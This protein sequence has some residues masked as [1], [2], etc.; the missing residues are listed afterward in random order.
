LYKAFSR[1]SSRPHG[2]LAMI[3]APD[4]L[5]TRSPPNA[6]SVDWIDAC[7]WIWPNFMTR[8]AP[9]GANRSRDKSLAFSDPP[10]GTHPR[11]ADWGFCYTLLSSIWTADGDRAPFQ[12][13]CGGSIACAH[14]NRPSPISR[15][16]SAPYRSSDPHQA[17][18]PCMA[19]AW[20][21]RGHSAI[22]DSLP[23][24][25]RTGIPE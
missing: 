11:G 3:L 16:F 1:C 23:P 18:S 17:P 22:L 4:L 14:V 13:S 9:A 25:P 19:G 21:C 8:L 15:G 20:P 5:R 24:G 10:E 12:L 7:P 6:R 2:L